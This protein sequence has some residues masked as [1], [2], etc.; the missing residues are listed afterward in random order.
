M[1]EDSWKTTIPNSEEAAVEI[2]RDKDVQGQGYLCTME[3]CQN[4]ATHELIVGHPDYKL[5]SVYCLCDDHKD[6]I[7]EL[8]RAEFAAGSVN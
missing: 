4:K 8:Y 3:K 6:Q 1:T 7:Y 2:K 5:G